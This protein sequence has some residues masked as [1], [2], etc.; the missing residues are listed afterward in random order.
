[1]PFSFGE[2]VE[3][4][5]V[6]AV[7]PAGAGGETTT[8]RDAEVRLDLDPEAARPRLTMLMFPVAF[9]GGLSGAGVSGCDG[10]A[11]VLMDVLIS[12]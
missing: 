9:E 8:P 5:T 11:E 4:S 7:D 6:A 10:T 3:N 12:L 1:V 2:S